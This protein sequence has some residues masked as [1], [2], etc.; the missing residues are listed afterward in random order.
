MRSR[1]LERAYRR[2][3]DANYRMAAAIRGEREATPQASSGDYWQLIAGNSAWSTMLAQAMGKPPVKTVIVM[4]A[5]SP[6]A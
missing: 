1:V 4:Q 3:R 2:G 6:T 5:D